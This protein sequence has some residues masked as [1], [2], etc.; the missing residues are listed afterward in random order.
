MGV[1]VARRCVAVLAVIV[2]FAMLDALK[3]VR[4]AL[5]LDGFP[6]VGAKLREVPAD[7]A[8]YEGVKGVG[9]DREAPQGAAASK[10][11]PRSTPAALHQHGRHIYARRHGSQE[12]EEVGSAEEED[13]KGCRGRRR[14]RDGPEEEDRHREAEE[15]AAKRR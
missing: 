1:S 2:L 13:P 4:P 5:V 15:V 10:D 8:D 6:S 7:D 11:S 14:H 12:D 3:A 9:H